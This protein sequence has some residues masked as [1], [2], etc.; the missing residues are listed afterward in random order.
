MRVELSDD[1]VLSVADTGPGMTA[2]QL[3]R[4]GAFRQFDRK[5]REQQ[6][7]GLGLFLARKLALRAGTDLVLD[8]RPGAGTTALL[9]LPLAAPPAAPPR[10]G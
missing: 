4:V 10:A 6:G 1:G 9:R 7:L 5:H 2:E 8:S 3:A